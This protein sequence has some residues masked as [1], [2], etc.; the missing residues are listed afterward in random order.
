MKMNTLISGGSTKYKILTLA[1]CTALSQ[2]VLAKS[3]KLDNGISGSWNTTISAGASMRM[4]DA[5]KDFIATSNGGNNPN[6]GATAQDDANLNFEKNDV[7]S[8]VVKVI[9]EIDLNKGD[10]RFFA[11]AKAWYDYTLSNEK[12]AHGHQA[13]G[14]VPNTKLDDS[15]FDDQNKFSGIELLDFYVQ[16]FF[17]VGGQEI[18]AKI[19]R[20]VANW[21][22]S[23]FF[24]GVNSYSVLDVAALRRPGAEL[25]EALM[26]VNQLQLSFPFESG[27]T[28]DAFYQFSWDKTTVDGCGTYFSGAD[29]GFDAS[30]NALTLN[31]APDATALASGLLLKRAGDKEPSDSGQFGVSAKYF[32]ENVD[33]EFGLYYINYHSH[34]PVIS[35]VAPGG[36]AFFQGAGPFPPFIPSNP[37]TYKPAAI[38]N[39]VTSPEA[40]YLLEYP[41]DIQIIGLSATTSLLGWSVAGEL[42][43]HK[44]LPV[45]INSPDALTLLAQ[46][47]GPLASEYGVAA[48]FT[49]PVAGTEISG[50]HRKDKTQLQINFLKTWS[51]FLGASNTLFAGEIAMMSTSGIGDSATDVRYGRAPMFGAATH[52]T[53]GPNGCTTVPTP[54]GDKSGAW[55]AQDGFVT[56]FSWGYKFKTEL[57]YTNLISGTAVKPSLFVAHDVSGYSPDGMISEDRKTIG[58]GLKF[59]INKTHVVNF[60]YN[61]YM[62][63]AEFDFL[64]DRDFLSVSVSTSF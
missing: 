21:G 43:F 2:P 9:S 7:Y 47:M 38:G 35:A 53:T 40:A 34:L 64:S 54:A 31:V 62:N 56:D 32:V 57:S 27:L 50:F 60:T 1:V 41:E 25:K 48:P 3:F 18:D 19:G 16:G 42:S 49:G 26:P 30:C 12:V 28:I 46:G 59:D 17:E 36:A 4:E 10:F 8:S 33:T 51:Q 11:R 24:L 55:C 63:D 61:N 22:E 37:A 23:L 15:N 20:S 44:D 58:L 39:L 29:I 6:L 5:N 14:Y 13:T 52:A 45:Q